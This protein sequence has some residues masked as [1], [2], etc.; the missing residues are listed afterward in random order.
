MPIGETFGDRKFDAEKTWV[1]PKPL[2]FESP[3]REPLPK[4]QEKQPGDEQR[5]QELLTRLQIHQ[6]A[7]NLSE[8]AL[9]AYPPLSSTEAQELLNLLSRLQIEATPEEVALLQSELPKPETQRP[10]AQKSENELQREKQD[11]LLAEKKERGEPLSAEER[12]FVLQRAIQTVL[13]DP[14]LRADRWGGDI[15]RGTEFLKARMSPQD[16]Q[17]LTNED[18]WSV[19]DRFNDHDV[20]WGLPRWFVKPNK[21]FGPNQKKQSKKS[22]TKTGNFT[23]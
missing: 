10:Q 13:S 2:T 21:P 6:N 5:A 12:I 17:A 22:G 7:R 16:I 18:L 15:N 1:A 11:R 19:R 20:H 8:S 14:N 3:Q 9:R 23:P 4:A